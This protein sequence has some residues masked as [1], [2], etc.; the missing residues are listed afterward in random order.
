MSAP[1]GSMIIL[2]LVDTSLPVS[3]HGEFGIP[4]I[5]IQLCYC[6]PKMQ[7]KHT[8]QALHC[9]GGVVASHIMQT[10]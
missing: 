7:I 4:V 3:L 8:V 10:V 9:V 5:N 1:P 2:R 6:D